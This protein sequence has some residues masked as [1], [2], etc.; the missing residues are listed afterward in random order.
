MLG[1]DFDDI[2]CDTVKAFLESQ[3]D[4]TQKIEFKR[5]AWI[6][7]PDKDAEKGD[8]MLKDITGMA[9]AY[10]GYILLGVKQN[11][12][13]EV[14]TYEFFNIPDHDKE[15]VRIKQR[16]NACIQ[17]R[18]DGFK[19]KSVEMTTLEKE[20]VVIL[21]LNVPRGINA[22]HAAKMTDMR[23]AYW[24]WRR[25]GDIVLPMQTFDIRKQIMDTYFGTETLEKKFTDAFNHFKII[26]HSAP[27]YIWLVASP[28]DVLS[29]N[30]VDIKNS[31][32]K[33]A[34]I[35]EKSAYTTNPFQF[36]FK[37]EELKYTV[38]GLCAARSGYNMGKRI[39]L[40]K[41]GFLQGIGFSILSEEPGA[42]SRQ[43][44][45]TYRIR[46][47]ILSFISQ[48]YTLYQNANIQGGVDFQVAIGQA[49]GCKL[50][51]REKA[52]YEIGMA[53]TM[54]VEN[55]YDDTVPLISEIIHIDDF[56][57]KQILLVADD[58]AEKV[59]NGFG[60]EKAA[61]FSQ[62]YIDDIM[63]QT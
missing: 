20:R 8:E 1:K 18:L 62:E 36:T 11:K 49:Q 59:W 53:S 48:V 32:V 56:D 27:P 9:N 12:E 24:F 29:N 54:I 50:P 34:F 4:E 45:S 5:E 37:S 31:A 44:L 38:R 43:L 57:R 2:D 16:C 10:G 15:M 19:I 22:P 40:H 30:R 6:D 46:S 47:F 63:S 21:I 51:N 7:K 26:N 17:P 60:F 35:N 3:A 61:Q 13:N 28:A 23:A 55:S 39:E 14:I 42:S 41:S 33:Q 52:Q 58:L 25:Y